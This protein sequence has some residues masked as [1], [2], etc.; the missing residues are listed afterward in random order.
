[1]YPDNAGTS[2]VPSSSLSADARS[3]SEPATTRNPSATA[4]ADTS[5][6]EDIISKQLENKW[7]AIIVA[8]APLGSKLEEYL[9]EHKMLPAYYD[10]R[11]V[12]S[13]IRSMPDLP[14]VGYVDDEVTIWVSE[15]LEIEDELASRLFGSAIDFEDIVGGD[16]G[17]H[18][19]DWK[20]TESPPEE[21]SDL[22]FVE[23][24]PEHL[25]AEEAP[26]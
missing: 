15:S 3:D 21:V 23:S 5:D 22:D 17:Y 2:S 7:R 6:Q 20:P 13:V 25:A 1:L 4:S 18:G 24:L 11:L 8:K 14:G 10:L 26:Y 12:V 19:A 16:I 9:A